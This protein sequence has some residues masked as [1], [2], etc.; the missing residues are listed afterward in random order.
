MTMAN[1]IRPAIRQPPLNKPNKQPNS[2]L[3]HLYLPFDAHQETIWLI[4]KLSKFSDYTSFYGHYLWPE[5]KFYN[6]QANS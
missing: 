3:L 2:A 5:Q 6:F 1:N 4:S